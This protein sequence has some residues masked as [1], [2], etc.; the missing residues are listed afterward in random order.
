MSVEQLV[1]EP[2][3]DQLKTENERLKE[4]LEGWKRAATHDELTDVLNLRGFN[5]AVEESFNQPLPVEEFSGGETERHPLDME[6]SCLLYFDLDHFKSVNDTLGHPAG[7]QALIAV[8]NFWR[9]NLRPYDIFARKGGDEFMV[10]FRGVSANDIL[11]KFRNKSTGVATLS[12][13]I[14]L[15]GEEISIDVSG[16]VVDLDRNDKASLAEA[17]Q[18]ADEALYY[19]KKEGRSRIVQYTSEGM[20]G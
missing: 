3:Y 12:F 6:K 11:D 4:E 18:R 7:D 16:G 19:A 8:T 15:E 10:L 2:P 14:R 17:E 9:E 5:I 1:Q 20:K 13:A